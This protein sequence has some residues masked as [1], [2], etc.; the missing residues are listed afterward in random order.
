LPGPVGLTFTTGSCPWY[1]S[2]HLHF[3]KENIHSSHFL[4]P[5]YGGR[6]PA[7]T[8]YFSTFLQLFLHFLIAL[9]YS[10]SQWNVNINILKN[11]KH[12]KIITRNHTKKAKISP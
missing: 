5:L 12:P 11:Y 1:L 7:P 9:P 10:F 2:R 6:V 3:P 8:G 4:S